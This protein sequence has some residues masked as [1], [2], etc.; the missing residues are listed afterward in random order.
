MNAQIA[1]IT[2]LGVISGA[3]G[4]KGEELK[5]KGGGESTEGFF[6]RCFTGTVG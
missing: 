2:I 4:V 5:K 6:W 3:T 1:P